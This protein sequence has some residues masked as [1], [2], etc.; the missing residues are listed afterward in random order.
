MIVADPDASLNPCWPLPDLLKNCTAPYVAIQEQSQPPARRVV[1]LV[2]AW[3]G[4]GDDE[5]AQ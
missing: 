4:N 2:M 1:P 3:R 5:H